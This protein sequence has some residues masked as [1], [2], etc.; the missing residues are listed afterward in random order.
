MKNKSLV[1]STLFI[2][3]VSF[4]LLFNSCSKEEEELIQQNTND[5]LEYSKDIQLYD[6]SGDNSVMMRVSSD[7]QSFVE[8]Y[9][10]DNFEVIPV[11]VGQSVDEVLEEY[12][13]PQDDPE[14]VEEDVDTDSE[15]LDN[16]E[17]SI[18]FEIVS[19]DL[20]DGIQNVLITYLHPDDGDDRAKWRY[21]DHY[22]YHDYVTI[23]RVSFWRRVYLGVY[24]QANSYS[25]P[26]STITG[27]WYKLSNN[28]QHNKGKV[29]SYRLKARIKTKKSSAYTIEFGD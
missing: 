19:K 5:N 27:T 6:K 28:E 8:L 12:Y 29:G 15:G 18:A 23:T 25:S 20:K 22:S 13:G 2:A 10:T 11:K 7:D 24:Y 4:A 17:P 21:Y 26:W 3:V 16:E 1:F 14:D 9:S